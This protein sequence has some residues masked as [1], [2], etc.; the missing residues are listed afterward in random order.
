ML[1]FDCYKLYFHSPLHIGK[2][3]IGEESVDTTI[4]S[5]TL[6]SAIIWAYSVMEEER[7]SQIIE[8]AVSGKPDFLI[9]STFPFDGEALYFPVPANIRLK[10]GGLIK[11]EDFER[12][13]KGEK[14]VEDAE[15]KSYEI[16]EV[17]K[18]VQSRITGRTDIYSV[19]ETRFKPNSGLYF[20]AKGDDLTK[21]LKYLGEVGIGGYRSVGKGRFD[22]KKEEIS[23]NSGNKHDFFVTLSLFLPKK[24]EIELL[25]H[26]KSRYFLE[27]RTGWTN[28]PGMNPVKISLRMI[29]EGSVLP[30]KNA[31]EIYGCMWKSGMVF[32][33]GYAFDV[34]MVIED[35]V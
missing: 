19:G 31:E 26:H 32:R 18:N 35:E 7:I 15:V 28:I 17:S 9:S 20:L 29:Q 30:K 16:S 2:K 12:V 23:F 22:L 27:H 5:D 3:G 34:P 10:R 21:V 25:K 14:E 6:F 13:I 11:K 1:E 4:R 8:N 33:Y 24:N